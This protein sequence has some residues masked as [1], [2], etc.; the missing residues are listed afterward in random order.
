MKFKFFAA[1]INLFKENPW[2]T[3][4]SSFFIGYVCLWVTLFIRYTQPLLL[5]SFPRTLRSAKINLYWVK[6][7]SEQKEIYIFLCGINIEEGR[8]GKNPSIAWCWLNLWEKSASGG[9]FFYCYFKVF[10]L[11]ECR[12]F[13]KNLKLLTSTPWTFP[14]FIF[15]FLLLPCIR[16]N[17]ILMR[18]IS[19][20][21]TDN[22]RVL[23]LW[24]NFLFS[25]TF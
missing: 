20:T 23:K 21:P 9:H 15:F 14:Y 13:N 12:A 6:Y 19:F 4:M 2:K 16:E 3:T 7:S 17:E 25:S 24:S 22:T 1:H 18:A 11:I 8:E 10:C 5:L